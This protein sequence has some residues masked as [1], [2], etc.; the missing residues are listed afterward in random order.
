M[1][2]RGLEE[3]DVVIARI[4]SALEDRIGQTSVNVIPMVG[5]DNSV[6][7]RGPETALVEFDGPRGHSTVAGHRLLFAAHCEEPD[8]WDNVERAFA[9]EGFQPYGPRTST[10]IQ[11]YQSTQWAQVVV[12]NNPGAI[13]H[14]DRTGRPMIGRVRGA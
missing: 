10:G 1:A 5:N 11:V 7:P 4:K 8:F 6:P 13:M 2:Y 12:E 3:R 14:V 9:A